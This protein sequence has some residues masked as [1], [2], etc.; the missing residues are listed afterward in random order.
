MK[1]ISSLFALIFFGLIS[2]QAQNTMHNFTATDTEGHVHRLYED[3]SD[4]GKVVVIKFF[5]STCPPCIANAPLWQ[6]KYIQWG[7][8][9]ENVEF[10]SATT[11]TSDN[12]PQVNNFENTYNQ[13]MKGISNEGNASAVVSPF[14]NGVYGSWY[15]TPSFA[16]IAPDRKLYYPVFFEELDATIN[17]AKSPVTSA[18]TTVNVQLTTDNLDIPSGHIKLFIKPKNAN[19]PK[20]EIQKNTDGQYTFTYP[21]ANY[22]EMTEPEVVMESFGPAYTTKVSASDILAI[23]KHILGLQLLS[24][25][26]KLIAADVTGDS[27]ITASDLLNIRKVILGLSTSFPNNTPSYKAIPARQSISAS[28]GN[29]IPVNFV[30]VKTGNVN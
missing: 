22:P 9:N 24:P 20:V 29:T 15:G 10:F 8:G 16:V 14:R 21:S 19:N 18:V 11:L 25:S 28:P 23:Q 6:Q 3:Y 5:F 2:G 1:I 17:L 26:Y 30:V 7:S 4:K 27:K 12:N 13:T